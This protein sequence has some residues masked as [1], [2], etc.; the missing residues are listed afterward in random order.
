MCSS[1]LHMVSDKY[2]NAVSAM[3]I[4]C[5]YRAAT[6]G[7]HTPTFSAP[8]HLTATVWWHCYRL[9]PCF[10]CL[11]IISF[12]T[13]LSTSI[14]SLEH[15]GDCSVLILSLVYLACSSGHDQQRIS[16][17][18]HVS[19]VVHMVSLGKLHLLSQVLLFS[20]DVS[21]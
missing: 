2:Q 4:I 6:L 17:W 7:V 11:H 20:V 12:T 1:V 19:A 9:Q 10:L 18:W 21:V 3:C 5:I 8:M 13:S 16:S 15:S 14:S